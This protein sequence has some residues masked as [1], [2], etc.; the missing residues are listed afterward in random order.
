[1]YYYVVDEPSVQFNFEGRYGISHY[2]VLLFQ[3]DGWIV[4][5]LDKWF[6]K[7]GKRLHVKRVLGHFCLP[8]QF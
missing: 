7:I 8:S 3:A 1:M 5:V 6:G 2:A 4:L